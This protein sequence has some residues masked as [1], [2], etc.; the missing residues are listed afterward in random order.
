M[1]QVLGIADPVAGFGGSG[2]DGGI[3]IADLVARRY[4]ERVYKGARP[5]R[6][7][8]KRQPG[9]AI[10][11]HLNWWERQF[12]GRHSVDIELLQ[13]LEGYHDILLAQDAPGADCLGRILRP[14]A[15]GIEQNVTVNENAQ[16]GQGRSV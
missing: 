16:G 11:C 9:A 14:A 7:H 3:P 8:W 12:L 13:R 4:L 2:Q 1:V 6:R 15:R 10:G 5:K